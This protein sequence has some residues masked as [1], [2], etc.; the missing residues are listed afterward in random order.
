MLKSQRIFLPLRRLLPCFLFLLAGLPAAPTSA[1]GGDADVEALLAEARAVAE[2]TPAEV[3]PSDRAVA[4]YTDALAAAEASAPRLVGRAA[5]ELAHLHR[6]RGE[7]DRAAE[8]YRLAAERIEIFDGPDHP[9]LAASLYNLAHLELERGNAEAAEE[10]YQRALVIW[11]EASGP[12]HPGVLRALDDLASLYASSARWAEAQE[13]LVRLLALREE[14]SGDD[15]L[16]VALDHAATLGHLALL[17]QQQGRTADA[18]VL[19]DRALTFYARHAPGHPDVAATLNNLAALYLADGRLGAAEPLL[20]RALAMAASAPPERAAELDRAVRENLD[21]LE[22]L[23]GAPIEGIPPRAAPE[24]AAPIPAAPQDAAPSPPPPSVV[25]REMPP[26][27]P[28]PVEEKSADGEGYWAQVGSRQS[29]ADAQARL[30][31]V[32]AAHPDLLRGA[33]HRLQSVDLGAKGV[34]H[35]VQLGPFAGRD[36]A[37]EICRRL[38]ASGDAECLP[39][40]GD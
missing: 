4:L 14:L 38:A 35:R 33:A 6:Q 12:R 32:R 39:V 17:H 40:R 5:N 30:D 15:E 20:R 9:N 29:A 26:T 1:Q 11:L 23:R 36:A 24:S 25:V 10:F 8:F 18:E 34:W 31:A 7:L 22:A 16:N 21:R 19:Y 37:Q 13:L 27:P 28:Q 2:Q 3:A